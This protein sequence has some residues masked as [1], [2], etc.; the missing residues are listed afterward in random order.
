VPRL[1]IVASARPTTGFG[2]VARGIAAAVSNSFET[3]LFGHDVL[4]PRPEDAGLPYRIHPG[5][6]HDVFGAARLG[7]LHDEVRPDITLIINDYWYVFTYLRSLQNSQ[8]RSMVAFYAP[9]DARLLDPR[10]LVGLREIDGLALY[11]QFG[12]SVV[13]DALAAIGERLDRSRPLAVIGHGVDTDRFYPLSDDISPRAQAYRR[14]DA[15]I[16][17][18][19]KDDPRINGF[20]VLNANKNSQRKR[21]DLTMAGFALFAQDKPDDVRLYVHAGRRDTGPDLQRLSRNLGLGDRL[22]VTED[23]KYHP[24]VSGERL[25]LIYNACDVGVNTCL[26]EGWG[27]VAFEHAA[28][29]AAQIL[30]RHSALAELWESSAAFL[31]PVTPLR[32]G[33]FLEGGA[34]T[35]EQLAASLE[36]LYQD[37]DLLFQMSC[38][39]YRNALRPEFSWPAVGV[40]W[41]RFLGSM[42]SMAAAQ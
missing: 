39:A 36:L 7:L 12:K 31:E 27:L 5:S 30:P 9:V 29:K 2:R 33:Q 42:I 32:F 37:R 15:R 6:R 16:A 3:H 40:E 13:L 20:W 4:E 38:A 28:T 22:I 41:R 26:G 35:P 18:L 19:G 24:C 17:L 14:R 21:L 34:T 25:N 10:Q 8:H 23:A 1:L 11:T